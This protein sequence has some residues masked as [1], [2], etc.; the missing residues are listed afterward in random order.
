MHEDNVLS[1]MTINISV[2]DDLHL[3][4]CQLLSPVEKIYSYL[5]YAKFVNDKLS[6]WRVETMVS[7]TV[8]YNTILRINAIMEITSLLLNSKKE[9]STEH[10]V[11]YKQ[12]PLEVMIVAFDPLVRKLSRQQQSYWKNLEFEDLC[13]MCRLVIC[14]LYEKG[15]YIHKSLLYRAFTNYVLMQLRKS[16]FCPSITSLDDV[17]CIDQS[18][19][20]LTA[21]D[22][23]ADERAEEDMLEFEVIDEINDILCRKRQVII[24][25]IGQR[26]YDQLVREYGNRTTTSWSRKLV[27]KLKEYLGKR[28][29]NSRS[30]NE[31]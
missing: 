2:D 25:Y 28:G 22:M 27:Y 19:N 8:A 24:D 10:I 13:Q 12:P 9:P 11:G 14:L 20:I 1:K 3:K 31:K 29:I 26:Q 23:L 17:I 15:Y 16:R 5:V 21:E 4:V 18:G 30:F 7:Q 6:G